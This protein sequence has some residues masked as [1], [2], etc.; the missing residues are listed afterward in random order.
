MKKE[1]PEGTQNQYKTIRKQSQKRTLKNKAFY[2]ILGPQNGPR[3][4]KKE[5]GDPI[6]LFWGGGPP[7]RPPKIKVFGSVF[8][9]LK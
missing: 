9:C 6:A 2:T 4:Q 3:N 8:S 5:M 1:V 7:K